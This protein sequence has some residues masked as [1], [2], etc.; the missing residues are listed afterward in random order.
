M[1]VHACNPRRLR[2]EAHEFQASLCYIARPCL[3]N[4]TKQTKKKAK[5]IK[6]P[7]I[8]LSLEMIKIFDYIYF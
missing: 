1:A 7:E 8:Y 4:K 3:K 2:Q 5:Q 6:N